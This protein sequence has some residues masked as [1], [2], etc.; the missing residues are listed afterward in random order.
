VR[1]AGEHKR[2]KRAG[3]HGQAPD[4]PHV[5]PLSLPGEPGGHLPLSDP[6]SWGHTFVSLGV[7]RWGDKGVHALQQMLYDL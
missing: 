3:R 2:D 7:A 6:L 4:Q 1:A 5:A